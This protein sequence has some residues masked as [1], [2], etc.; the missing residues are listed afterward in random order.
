[1]IIP[2]ETRL[3]PL[4]HQLS[5]GQLG[6]VEYLTQLEP[7]FNTENDRIKAFLPEENRFVRLRH[8]AEA[9]EARYPNPNERPP[10][11]GVPVGVKDIFNVDGFLTRGGSKLPPEELAGAQAKSVTQLKQAGALILGKT[12]TT[13]FAYFGP[14]PTR[15]P[16]NIEHTPGGS[17]S[18]SAAAVGA[19]IA[20]L[21]LGTQ[22]I[23]SVIRPAAFCGAVGYK[24]TAKRISIE[25]VIPLSPS[26]DHVGLFTQDLEG[27][28]LAASVLC[29]D[30]VNIPAPT[31]KPVLGIPAG[32]YL[33]KITPEGKTHFQQVQE[34]LAA[35]GFTLLTVEVMAGF[36]EVVVWHNELMAGEMAIVHQE[37]FKKYQ[38][39]YHPKTAALIQRGHQVAPESIKVYQS[40]REWL[41]GE[42]REMMIRHNISV[43]ISPPALGTAPKG[44]DFTG[45]PVMNLPWTYAGAP[46]ITV[47]AGTGPNGLPLGLQ[48]AADCNRDEQLVHWAA[49]ISQALQAQ[50]I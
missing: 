33:E 23:G 19:G 37:W 36:D 25:G 1:M 20:P 43:W 30:W 12:V 4:A 3:A 27:L 50:G 13:E 21:A 44:I 8:E 18:G 10:L 7:F 40:E 39:L 38:D 41:R 26:L 17:S 15:N 42:L 47:P 46:V 5:S 11:F 35:A 14:G 6:L 9:L 22:T 49:Q 16:H 31:K 48:L 24:P 34:K 2:V 45:D 28:A 32:P 29:K